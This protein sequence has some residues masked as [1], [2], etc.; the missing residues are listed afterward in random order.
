LWGWIW[1]GRADLVTE[2]A[3]LVM[4]VS[5]N[6]RVLYDRLGSDLCPLEAGN[7]SVTS[8]V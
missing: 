4:C 5:P 3:G 8:D 7:R 1:E 6:W 2:A